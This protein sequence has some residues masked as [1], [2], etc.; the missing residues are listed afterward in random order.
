MKSEANKF[1][2]R[3]N[4]AK[5]RSNCISL[6]RAIVDNCISLVDAVDDNDVTSSRCRDDNDVEFLRHL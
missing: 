3:T 1:L 4:F 6:R 5:A 2:R